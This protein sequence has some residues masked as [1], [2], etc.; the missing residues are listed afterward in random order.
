MRALPEVYLL[1]PNKDPF[2]GS[3]PITQPATLDSI[4]VLE[5]RDTSAGLDPML[6]FSLK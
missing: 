3:K 6:L 5:D 2:N 4:F 1:F